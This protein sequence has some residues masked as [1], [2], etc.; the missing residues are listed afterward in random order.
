MLIF[1]PF[2]L[3]VLIC[4]KRFIYLDLILPY[5]FPFVNTCFVFSMCIFYI[6]LKN[7]KNNSAN[8]YILF[9][10]TFH[11]LYYN[12]IRYYISGQLNSSIESVLLCRRN[13]SPRGLHSLQIS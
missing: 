12:N 5:F 6:L 13:S 1:L 8:C 2:L 9:L 10:V 4:V 3:N 11:H 7:H